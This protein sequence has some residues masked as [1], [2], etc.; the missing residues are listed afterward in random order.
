MVEINRK[1]V[2]I[3]NPGGLVPGLTIETLGGRSLPRN[4]LIAQLFLRADE[5][6]KAGTGIGRIRKAVAQAALEPPVFSSDTFFSISLPLPQTPGH[7]PERF[8]PKDRIEPDLTELTDRACKILEL[9]RKEGPLSAPRL[10]ELLGERVTLR[11]LQRELV[12]LANAGAIVIE[13]KARATLY[14]TGGR[15]G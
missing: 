1:K 2:E 6:E 3:V 5:V 9:V 14:K 11:S 8:G 4:P 15:S 7:V 12:L 13:G 10:Q